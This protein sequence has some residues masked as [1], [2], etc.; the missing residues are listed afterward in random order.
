[1]VKGKTQNHLTQSQS[2]VETETG[3]D[4]LEGTH[5]VLRLHPC[6]LRNSTKEKQLQQIIVIRQ[7]EVDQLKQQLEEAAARGF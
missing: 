7:R 3:P 4:A 5:L 1:M 2:V 6:Q